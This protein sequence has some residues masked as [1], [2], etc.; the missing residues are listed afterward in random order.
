MFSETSDDSFRAR[1]ISRAAENSPD[2]DTS[3]ANR[4]A[5]NHTQ[6]PYQCIEQPL[7][8]ELSQ[9]KQQHP[10]RNPPQTKHSYCNNTPQRKHHLEE[11]SCAL[12]SAKYTQQRTNCHSDYFTGYSPPFSHHPGYATGNGMNLNGY[13]PGPEPVTHGS[14]SILYQG[15]GYQYTHWESSE[16]INKAYEQ[17]NGKYCHRPC[18]NAIACNCYGIPNQYGTNCDPRMFTR[19]DCLFG[20]HGFVD[21]ASQRGRYG[22]YQG[23]ARE[24]NGMRTRT[25]LSR[26]S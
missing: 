4:S 19:G 17:N 9:A 11:P 7:Y 1:S 18:Q 14:N 13:C 12:T 20:G 23:N 6:I 16:T 25:V 21:F 22:C 26:L 24:C 10:Y 5:G 2:V 3:P 8:C 15:D